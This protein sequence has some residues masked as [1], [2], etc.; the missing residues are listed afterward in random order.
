MKEPLT[1]KHRSWRGN[2]VST[3]PVS[4]SIAEAG[5][6]LGQFDSVCFQ[7]K[8]NRVGPPCSE[9]AG[10]QLSTASPAQLGAKRVERVPEYPVGQVVRPDCR[11]ATVGGEPGGD[12][13]GAFGQNVDAQRPRSRVATPPAGPSPHASFG[14][15][16]RVRAERHLKSPPYLLNVHTELPQRPDRISSRPEC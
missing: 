3:E 2:N 13:E 4:P 1:V 11:L 6:E 10:G 5:G 14:R 15:L 7:V 8:A 12:L 9:A 16:Q